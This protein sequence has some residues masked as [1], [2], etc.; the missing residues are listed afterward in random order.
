M[1]ADEWGEGCGE[2]GMPAAP[3]QQ[4]MPEVEGRP[5][6]V[7]PAGAKDEKRAPLSHVTCAPGFTQRPA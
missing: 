4:A 5:N 7:L 6:G 3:W 1:A 2:K